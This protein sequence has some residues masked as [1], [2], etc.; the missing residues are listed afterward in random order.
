M[1]GTVRAAA[2]KMQ[3]LDRAVDD[4]LGDFFAE[5]VSEVSEFLHVEVDRVLG[6]QMGLVYN[7]PV[8]EMS[9]EDQILEKSDIKRRLRAYDSYFV[10]RNGTK[11][12]T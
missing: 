2:M 3:A 9:A 11:V 10:D 12:R 7:R 8:S 1:G 5:K 4:A 6:G